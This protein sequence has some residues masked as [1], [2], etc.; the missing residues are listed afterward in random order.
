MVPTLQGNGSQYRIASKQEKETKWEETYIYTSQARRQ[1]F[2]KG[3][4]QGNYRIAH[5]EHSRIVLNNRY[6]LQG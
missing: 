1:K 4:S 6:T 2:E 3:G 5:G